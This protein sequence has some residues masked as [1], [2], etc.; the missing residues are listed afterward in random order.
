MELTAAGD[1][2]TMAYFASTVSPSLST[3]KTDADPPLEL[4]ELGLLEPELFGR[5]GQQRRAPNAA[6]EAVVE[7]GASPSGRSPPPASPERF[8]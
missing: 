6:L 4:P 1:P 2:V 3:V 8:L 7:G 5:A